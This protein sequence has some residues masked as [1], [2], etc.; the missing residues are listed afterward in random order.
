MKPNARKLIR[1][2]QTLGRLREQMGRLKT[3][4][5]ELSATV[6]GLMEA[7]KLTAAESADYAA[8]LA[9]TRRLKIDARTFKRQV[10]AKAF[11]DCVRVDVTTAR[12]H[13][14]TERLERIGD[15]ETSVKLQVSRRPK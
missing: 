13:L 14:T 5:R 11:L 2:V 10:G 7:G 4:E 3:S 9:E 6:R 15:I 8:R 1:D 12:R